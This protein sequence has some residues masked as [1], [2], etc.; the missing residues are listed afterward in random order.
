MDGVLPPD[1]TCRAYLHIG[2]I[3]LSLLRKLQQALAGRRLVLE[4][5]DGEEASLNSCEIRQAQI[6]LKTTDLRIAVTHRDGQLGLREPR[7]TSNVPKEFA[8]GR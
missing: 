3:L 6:L 2:T 7:P 1:R 5:E 8:E 4:S